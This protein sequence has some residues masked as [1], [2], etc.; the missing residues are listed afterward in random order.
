MRAHSGH[1]IDRLLESAEPSV[2]WKVCAEVLQEPAD[3]TSMRRLR[4]QVRQSPRVKQLLT[5]RGPNGRSQVKKGVYAKWQGARWVI[6]ALAD[7][8]YPP[9]DEDLR[10]MAEQVQDAWLTDNFYEE[11]EATSNASVYNHR[12]V[13]VIEGRYR[14]CASQQGNVLRS[15]CILDLTN[16]DTPKLVE[17]LLHW[18][19]PDGGWNCDKNPE[20]D[21]SAFS[22]TLLPMRGLAAYAKRT[23]DAAA[24]TA[25]ERASEILL[26]RQLMFPPLHRRADPPRVRPPALPALLAL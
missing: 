14:R 23:G 5:D 9:G 20:A 15:L 8:G 16:D 24:K 19:W 13:P 12:G 7:L 18:Q 3:S 21:T 17:R 4:E 1:V 22:E 10:P 2:Q 11:F 6:A 26:S 25:A